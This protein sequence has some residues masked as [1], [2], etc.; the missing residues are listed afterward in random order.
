ME[1]MDSLYASCSALWTERLKSSVAAAILALAFFRCCVSS[2]S[3]AGSTAPSCWANRTGSPATAA[4]RYST[5]GRL[6]NRLSTTMVVKHILW[7]IMMLQDT[8]RGQ[9]E[10]RRRPITA[11]TKSHLGYRDA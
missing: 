10:A 1:F 2:C 6:S 8:A 11:R 9:R 4:S 3:I 5:P 7:L